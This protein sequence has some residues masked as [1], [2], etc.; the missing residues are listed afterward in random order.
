MAVSLEDFRKL[1][2][3]VDDWIKVAR[4][5]HNSIKSIKEKVASLEEKVEDLDENETL[6][7]EIETL[8][9]QRRLNIKEIADISERIK[10]IE[11]EH[12][13]IRETVNMSITARKVCLA[14]VKSLS[15]KIDQFSKEDENG[16]TGE[17]PSKTKSKKF[18][19]KQC[20]AV[21][22]LKDNLRCHIK[23]IHKQ[24]KQC[25]LCSEK[26]ED[27]SKL[28]E[29][30]LTVHKKSKRFHCGACDMT[31]V[32]R[33]RLQKHLESHQEGKSTIKCHYYNN[34][35]PCPFENVGCKY[36]H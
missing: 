10:C 7:H 16:E 21:F 19:C 6:D 14:E 30:L 5:C 28:E 13:T 17:K 18:E 23:T 32:L 12:E 11:T 8:R 31:F 25:S 29:H 1:S 33:W 26:F 4:N 24:I 2:A 36:L 20:D 9:E 22:S 3:K 34:N 15:E 27:N 35:K